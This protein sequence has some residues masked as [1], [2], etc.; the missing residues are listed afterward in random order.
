MMKRRLREGVEFFRFLRNAAGH[1]LSSCSRLKTA[2][3]HGR[4]F[5]RR[6]RSQRRR[7]GGASRRHSDRR[8]PD[9]F[10]RGRG[11]RG[12]ARAADCLP[13]ASACTWCWWKAGRFCLPAAVSSPRQCGRHFP[14]RHG[15]AR[16]AHRLQRR[17]AARA[18]GRDHGAVRGLSGHRA[19]PRSLQRSQALSSASGDRSAA[20]AALARASACVPRV[21]RSS[22]H[23]CS[24]S[25]ESDSPRALRCSWRH[26]RCCCAGAFA[27]PG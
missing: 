17:G 25:I 24:D 16:H 12:G 2:D 5:R 13:C 4:R 19:D 15:R 10:R 26:G 21:C 1:G 27:P 22:P 23:T 11:G 14:F 18:G 8:Q 7:R 20:D 6:P 9:G 3:R